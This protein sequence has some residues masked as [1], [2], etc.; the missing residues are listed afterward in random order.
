MSA[1]DDLLA[2]IADEQAL[3]TKAQSLDD[4]GG[5]DDDADIAAMADGDADDDG[6]DDNEDDDPDLDGDDEAPMGKS[7]AVQLPDG[8]KAEAYDGTALVKSLLMQQQQIQSQSQEALTGVLSMLKSM[9]TTVS[10]QQAEI[11]ALRKSLERIG[12]QGRGRKSKLTVHEPPR[13]AEGEPEPTEIAGTIMSKANAAFASGRIN[14][15]DLNTIDVA[16]RRHEAPPS[17]LLTKIM[18]Q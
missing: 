12:E 11:K 8:T 2:E 15:R 18:A 16:L 3:M 9:R 13:V 5:D 6:I 10:S 4:D 17:A 7:F 1:F 14:G